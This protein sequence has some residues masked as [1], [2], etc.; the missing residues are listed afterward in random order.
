MFQLARIHIVAIGLVILIAIGAGLFM[1]QVK[2]R[3][4]RLKNLQKD[5]EAKEAIIS[6]EKAQNDKLEKAQVA[7]K[8]AKAAWDQIMTTK[9]SPIML[10]DMHRAMFDLNLEA[11]TL[12][13]PLVKSLNHDP[14][15]RFTGTLSFP[16]IG[17]KEPTV[18]LSP[19]AFP[20]T[21]TFNAKSFASIKDWFIS[22]K[23]LQRVV[24]LGNSITLT[25]TTP[26][27]AVSI[28][29]TVTIF[30]PVPKVAGTTA[31]VAAPAAA[32]TPGMG[33]GGMPGMPGMGGMGMRGGGAP[34]GAMGMGGPSGMR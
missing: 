3:Q 25:A 28:P 23:Q 34:G 12:A 26:G 6:T 2:P 30:N 22:T 16:A 32:A 8:I 7:A 5:I 14:R 18:G 4:E 21:F 27:I 1:T 11:P 10:D 9:M 15:V 19:R 24:G 13:E 20:Q 31:V 33:G 17:W 29:G